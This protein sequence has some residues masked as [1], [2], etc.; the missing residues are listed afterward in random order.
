VK[1][2]ELGV[3][4]IVVTLTGEELEAGTIYSQLKAECPHCSQPSCFFDCDESQ[5][6]DSMESEDEART[7]IE[8]NRAYDGIETLILSLA[9]EG[10]DI[11][12]PAFLAGIEAA[13]EAVENN[14]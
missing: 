3:F 6:E 11:E 1:M 10:I 5:H 8:T 9:T 4:G 2:H 13:V 14:I 12:T 7:R